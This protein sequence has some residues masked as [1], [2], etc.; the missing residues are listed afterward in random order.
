VSLSFVKL[1][2]AG[3]V[4]LALDGRDRER[5]WPELARSLCRFHF[6]VGSHGLL[7]AR[8]S[9]RAAIGLR[10]F[11]SD[12]SEAEMSGNGVRL[13]TKYVLDRGMAR[14]EGGALRVE[15]GAGIR[16]IWPEFEAGR[17]IA[18]RVAM[19]R[20]EF[21][22]AALPTEPVLTGGAWRL[23]DHPLEV[24]GRSLDV[25]GL[26]LGNPHAV[27]LTGIPV[28]EFPLEEIGPAVERHP[29]FPNRINFEVVNVVDR[30]NLRVRVWERGEGETP[31]SGTGSTA[32]AVA[33]R[34]HGRVE[35]RVKVRLPG[36][37]LHVTWAGEGAEATLEGPTIEVFEGRLAPS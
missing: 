23:V 15:T 13:F 30:E 29:L 22:P 4:Y 20:P 2:A 31:S 21:S 10:I 28:A 37:A 18:G 36:G 11:N 6:G 12:G 34:L 26:S 5:D 35:E 25:T 14:L 33:A 19:G 27:H 24:A 8:P 16:R 9:Q 17:M 1:V 32:S 7:V 3:N